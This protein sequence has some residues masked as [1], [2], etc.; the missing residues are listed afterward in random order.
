[1]S[2]LNVSSDPSS[3]SVDSKLSR[4]IALGGG[5][6]FFIPN[7]VACFP[8]ASFGFEDLAFG[9]VDAESH[10]ATMLVIPDG[11]PP[12]GAPL[13]SMLSTRSKKD[14]LF[15][16][17]SGFATA[18]LAKGF[19]ACAAFFANGFFAVPSSGYQSR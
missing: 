12:F 2:S 10:S 3:V 14:V 19:E 7:S 6:P 16:A 15:I 11:N 18:C 4:V 5:I 8:L 9:L 1:M 17:S 13:N